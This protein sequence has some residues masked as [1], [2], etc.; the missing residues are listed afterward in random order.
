MFKNYE[1]KYEKVFTNK[2]R[3]KMRCDIDKISPYKGDPENLSMYIRQFKDE[4]KSFDLDLFDHL[5]KIYWLARRFCYDGERR[6]KLGKNGIKLD[7]AYGLFIRCFVGWD[8]KS[9]FTTMNMLPKVMGYFYDLFPNFDEG[10]PFKEKYE[11][12]FK[13]ISLPCL[14]IVYQM[15]ERMEML[16][17]A[18]S[19]KMNYAEFLD[20]VVNYVMCKSEEDD[21]YEI[22]LS[23]KYLPYVKKMKNN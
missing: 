5:V 21:K 9:I 6:E 10:N 2:E 1:D 16:K 15:D 13:Y 12:P 17:Y 19:K 23:M 4:T 3:I 18:E 7:A 22:V 8:T 14:F 11:Y 20:Y